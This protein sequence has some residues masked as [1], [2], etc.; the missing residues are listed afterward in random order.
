M[1]TMIQRLLKKPHCNFNLIFKH[2]VTERYLK[3]NN[4]KITQN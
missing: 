1:E 3:A 4:K 2:H